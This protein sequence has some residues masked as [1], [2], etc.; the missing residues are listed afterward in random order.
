MDESA[1]VPLYIGLG[2]NIGDRAQYLQQA[3]HLLGERLGTLQKVSRFW[4][5]PAADMDSKNDF[6][7]AAALLLCNKTPE[8]VL[9]ITQ[10][11]ECELGRTQKSVDGQHF[12][13]CIDIDILQYGL[14]CVHT[15]TLTLP[16]PALRMR[17]FVLGPLVEIAPNETYWGYLESLD[18]LED[19]STQPT[20]SQLLQAYEQQLP[21]TPQADYGDW[22]R[23]QKLLQQ[24][25]PQKTLT[26]DEYCCLIEAHQSGQIAWQCLYVEEQGIQ[27]MAA[28]A[29]L[30]FSPCPSGQKAWLEDLVVDERFRGRG[31]GRQLLDWAKA[32]AQS[33]GAKQLLL[34]SRP[35][36]IVANQLYRNYGFQQRDTNL[37][38]LLF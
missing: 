33:K 24:L 35:S 4:S 3:L 21:P 38:Q 36:R 9:R 10:D 20:F 11:I 5:T 1:L 26:W 16:H 2:S 28:M 8:E 13:R 6:L 31:L 22:L 34:T 25:S 17:R 7:N 29:V 27:F 37:Y 30:C 14:H 23:V 18:C 15:P 32:K 12:D 19:Y